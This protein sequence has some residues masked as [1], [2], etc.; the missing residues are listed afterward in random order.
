MNLNFVYR[1]ICNRGFPRL[2]TGP[3]TSHYCPCMM[4]P[5]P[6]DIANRKRRTQPNQ[7]LDCYSF[8]SF[9]PRVPCLRSP[10]PIRDL[11][12]LGW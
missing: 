12:K 2:E 5:S 1:W 10:L 7:L 9:S 3:N 4:R 6:L 11:S 8:C